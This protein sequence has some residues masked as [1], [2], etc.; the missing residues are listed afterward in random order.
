MKNVLVTGASGFIGRHLVAHLLE[1]GYSVTNLDI[2][3]PPDPSQASCWRQGSILDPASLSGAMAEVRPQYVIH[4]AALA[5]MEGRSLD[6]FK[7]N[8]DGTANLLAAIR[9]YGKTERVVVTSTQHVRKPGSPPPAHDE[10]YDPYML[11]GESKVVTE[12]LTRSSGLPGHW[13]IIRPTA[14]WG[15]YHPFQVVGLWKMIHKGLYVHPA[16]DFVLRAYGYV[17]NVAWQI[18][19]ILALPA[20][21]TSRRTFYVGDANSRQI[22]WINGFSRELTGRDVRTVPLWVIKA[23]AGFGDGMRA[24][25]LRFPIYGSRLFNL[26]TSNPVPMQSTFDVLGQGPVSMEEGIRKTSGWLKRHYAAAS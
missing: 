1:K 3:P 4:L 15:S 21:A 22:D 24:C 13:T 2:A 26:T 11:Y 18:E 10:D 16:H 14:V 9:S 12:K 6:D 19:R 25:G 23:L 17:G 5:V 8:T 20:E 7:A